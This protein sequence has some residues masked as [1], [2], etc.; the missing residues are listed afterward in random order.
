MKREFKIKGI[1]FKIVNDGCDN[2]SEMPY[3][4]EIYKYSESRKG[5]V[6]VGKCKT[7]AHGR[8]VAQDYMDMLE[9]SEY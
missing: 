7:L 4:Y 9:K 2:L 3:K 5:W 8:E 6:R 1:E